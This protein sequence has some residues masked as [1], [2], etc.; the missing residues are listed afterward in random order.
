MAKRTG[1]RRIAW[2]TPT[3]A[4]GGGAGLNRLAPGAVGSSLGTSAG[5]EYR[6]EAIRE[7]VQNGYDRRVRVCAVV[8][9][10]NRRDLLDRCLDRLQRQARPPDG[11]LVIDN[12]STD[13]TSD[14]LSRREGIEVRR[15]AENAG[16]AGGFERGLAAAYEAGY[17]WIWLL[18]DDTFVEETCL[19]ALLAGVERAPNP[20][21]VVSSVVEWRDSGTLHPMNGPWLRNG[22]GEL[23][24]AADARLAPI[25]A[26]TFVSTM[27]HRDAVQRHGLPPGHYFVWLDDIEYTARILRHEHGY[28][29]PDSVAL[30]WTPQ[31]YNTVTDSRERFYF[32]VRNQL[33][34]LR[35][36]SFGGRERLGYGLS[37][38]RGIAEYLRRSPSRGDAVRTVLKGLRD[39]LRREP[40]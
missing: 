40:R 8:V 9:T 7:P 28:V 38:L 34:L 10:Y 14:L 26:A 19:D 18:D 12:A 39:G 13:G 15:L 25:R 32:K 4:G 21:S 11:I 29:V 2:S 24:E 3:L 17:D 30:H 37:W 27:V 22:R 23:A 36:S 31:P 6:R 33:W 35:G 16:G 5:G 20:P 1:W